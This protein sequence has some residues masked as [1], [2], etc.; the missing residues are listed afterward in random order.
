M[1]DNKHTQGFL[2]IDG[3]YIVGGVKDVQ[4]YDGEEGVIIADFRPDTEYL[5]PPDNEQYENAKHIVDNW[6]EYD[7]LVKEREL[8]IE[9][10][11]DI[12]YSWNKR[13]SGDTE[14]LKTTNINGDI[15]EFW[16]PIASLIDSEP[17]HKAKELLNNLQIKTT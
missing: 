3:S 14:E 8:L 13:M 11:N 17:I 7:T 16:S 1:E 2:V 12:I 9:A 10:L 4:K 15:I 5:T 6:N